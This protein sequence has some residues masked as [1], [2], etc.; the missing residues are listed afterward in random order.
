MKSVA[1]GKVKENNTILAD[2][3][4]LT[5][6]ANSTKTFV[7]TPDRY[8]KLVSVSYNGEDVTSQLTSD[9]LFTTPAIL[10]NDTLKVVFRKQVF[11]IT[12][13]TSEGGTV[14]DGVTLLKNDTT[15]FVEYGTDKVFVIKALE[16]WEIETITYNGILVSTEMVDSIFT[17]SS[18][19]MDGLLEV[20]FKKSTSVSSI[21]ISNVKVYTTRSEIIIEGVPENELIR[22]Y[23]LN[24]VMIYNQKGESERM[25]IPVCEDAVYLVRTAGKTFKVIL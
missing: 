8:Y 9:S 18:I 11:G 19:S 3:A 24:G 6:E 5:V 12:I 7:I 20:V 15:I 23:T 13:K 1:G 14:K 2:S 10:K 21:D 16:E 4:L 17:A 25:V 22:I